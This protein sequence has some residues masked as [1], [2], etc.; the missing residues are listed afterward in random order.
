MRFFIL[1]LLVCIGLQAKEHAIVYIENGSLQSDFI[2]ESI[3]QARVFNPNTPIYFISSYLQY[4][5]FSDFF[6]DQDVFFVDREALTKSPLYRS[7]KKGYY[8][9]TKIGQN[10]AKE[11][12]IKSSVLKFILLYEF[13]KQI[14][15]KNIFFMGQKNMLYAPLEEMLDLF[16]KTDKVFLARYN[17]TCVSTNFMV[18]KDLQILEKIIAEILYTSYT[19]LPTLLANF[20]NYRS[21]YAEELTSAPKEYTS[22]VNKGH[23]DWVRGID[24][25]NILFDP[26]IHGSFLTNRAVSAECE[27]KPYFTHNEYTYSWEEDHKGRKIPILVFEQKK[28]RLAN[29]YLE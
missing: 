20:A 6:L 17:S 22:S 3:K 12:L 9:P 7:V 15:L 13:L 29:L 14:P 2:C 28:Y 23:M 21:M 4:K 24:F 5:K 11:D 8:C 1:T 10:A 25:K 16:F 19:S 26:G 27:G 18:I